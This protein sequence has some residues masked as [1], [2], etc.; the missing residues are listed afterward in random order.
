MNVENIPPRAARAGAER[1][2]LDAEGEGSGQ[3]AVEVPEAGISP[4]DFLNCA[5][6]MFLDPKAS[7]KASGIDEAA[8]APTLKF[9]ILVDQARTFA[10]GGERG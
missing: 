3:A 5:K 7:P 6:L 2:K 4:A 10:L 1:P 8:D 9:I